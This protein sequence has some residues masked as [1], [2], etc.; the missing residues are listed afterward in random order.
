VRFD[1][2]QTAYSNE[3]TRLQTASYH[4]LYYT[5]LLR[6]NDIETF[7]AMLTCGISP[8]PV[9]YHDGPHQP[10]VDDDDSDDHSNNDNAGVGAGGGGSS[11][12]HLCCRLGNFALLRI[13]LQELHVPCQVADARGRTPLHEC[14]GNRGIPSFE[15]VE[16]LLNQDVRLLYFCDDE[17]R[18][19]LEYIR[20]AD[21]S[22]WMVFL[23]RH[24]DVYWPVQHHHDGCVKSYNSRRT[25]LGAAGVNNK[26]VYCNNNNRRSSLGAGGNS[27]NM[28][29]RQQ[30]QQQLLL[31]RSPPLA[32]LP[33]NSRP[34]PD[35][36][37]ALP[38]H[39][40]ARVACGSMSPEEA[41]KYRIDSLL[42]SSS[43]SSYSNNENTYATMNSNITNNN[44]NSLGKMLGVNNKD[45][46][47]NDRLDKLMIMMMQCKNNNNMQSE[48]SIASVVTTTTT[49]NRSV[50]SG[51]S[52]C[53]S[54]GGGS[55]GS[56]ITGITWDEQETAEVLRS[57]TSGPLGTGKPI[58]W[59]GTS[60][61]THRGSG[62]DR[63]DHHHHHCSSSRNYNIRPAQHD[64]ALP[65]TL[66]T[67]DIVAV[68]PPLLAKA[69]TWCA[70]NNDAQQH[71]YFR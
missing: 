24:R 14:C 71:L 35:P 23:R 62:G 57:L 18:T 36:I 59:C 30:Q 68:P 3:P 61:N 34:L 2:L 65:G 58:A 46:K 43:S 45:D 17:G 4:D 42:L 27:G 54:C 63:G 32:L 50:A 9:Y 8:N 26:S 12:M 19:P 33:P 5:Q 40:A 29:H 21:W 49:A 52:S 39:I 60:S 15:A 70:N 41:T 69:A 47:N 48:K 25:S 13:L 55:V 10:A 37:H 11:L 6:E 64:I 53:N 38:I 22:A 56:N 44:N 7:R 51:L 1:T 28:L 31:Q 66:H 16:L 67:A 20:K